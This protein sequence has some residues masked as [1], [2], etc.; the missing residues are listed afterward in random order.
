MR[1]VKKI[2]FYFAF[3]LLGLF[4][5]GTLLDQTLKGD[6]GLGSISKSIEAMK[7]KAKHPGMP[8][9]EIQRLVEKAPKGAT[10]YLESLTNSESL[11]DA[12][13]KSIED[14]AAAEADAAKTVYIKASENQHALLEKQLSDDPADATLPK[15]AVETAP[16]GETVQLSPTTDGRE[17]IAV[18]E[19]SFE[20]SSDMDRI[21]SLHVS[22]EVRQQILSNYRKT[23]VLPDI[24]VKEVR[25]PAAQPIG[26]DDPY[27]QKNWQ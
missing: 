6:G 11:T 9:A 2:F 23:G 5:S 1:Q 19:N 14:A 18:V 26:S 3:G 15:G 17:V 13:L 7:L 12:H 27:N 24:L 8:A 20:P 10:G 4:A 25:K 22:E 16:G 21:N